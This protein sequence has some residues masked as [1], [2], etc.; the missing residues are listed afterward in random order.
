M[1]DSV[2]RKWKFAVAILA[3]SLSATA[4][5]A[6]APGE[7]RAVYMIALRDAPLVENATN[8]ALS[9]AKAPHGGRQAVRDALASPQSVAY[10]AQLDTS[11]NGGRRFCSTR[12][13]NRTNNAA[14]RARRG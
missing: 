6:A 14:H 5:V 2:R 3:T 12:C 9:G 11:R 13:Q 8:R 10:L 4:F 7:Q 1:I